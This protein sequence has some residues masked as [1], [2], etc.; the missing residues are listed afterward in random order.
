MADMQYA[1][2]S[3]ICGEKATLSRNSF[4]VD[5]QHFGYTLYSGLYITHV[6]KRSL[7]SV[8]NATQ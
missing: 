5:F 1:S 3:V 8:R 6:G 7:L 4:A 2:F